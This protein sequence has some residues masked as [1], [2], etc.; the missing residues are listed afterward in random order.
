MYEPKAEKCYPF[1][2]LLL[3]IPPG[4][5]SIVKNRKV[6]LSTELGVERM[7]ADFQRSWLDQPMVTGSMY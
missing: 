4:L 2:F 7:P 5:F 6:L 3:Q 1:F